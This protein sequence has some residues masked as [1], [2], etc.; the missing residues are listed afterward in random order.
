LISH[1]SG[2]DKKKK[3][4]ETDG[5]RLPTSERFDSKSCKGFDGFLGGLLTKLSACRQCIAPG[6][7]VDV[8][9][10]SEVYSSREHNISTLH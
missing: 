2:V 1:L 5:S 6:E 3:R 10:A 7:G 8:A 9:V 4:K